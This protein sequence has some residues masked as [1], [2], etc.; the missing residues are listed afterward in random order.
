[1]F[2]KTPAA[3]LAKAVAAAATLAPGDG[4]RFQVESTL[5]T[6]RDDGALEVQATDLVDSYWFT[7]RPPD[8]STSKPGRAFVGSENLARI[9]KRAGKADV[10]IETVKNALVVSWGDTV[11]KLPT[12]NPADA[13]QVVRYRPNDPSISI[14]ATALMSIMAKVNFA[15]SGDFKHR[16][17]AFV[18]VDIKRGRI[19]FAA[20]DGIRFAAVERDVETTDEVLDTAFVQPIK[21]ARIK[22]L[23]GEQDAQDLRVQVKNGYVA[24]STGDAEM[25]VRAG[26]VTWQDFDI[27]RVV[28][29]TKRATIGRSDLLDFLAGAG[30]L[31]TTGEKTCDFTFADGKLSMNA[32][33]PGEGSIQTSTPI[34]W[35][36]ESFMMRFDPVL[37]AQATS[38]CNGDRVELGLSTDQQPVLLRDAVDNQLYL[39]ALGARF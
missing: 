3:R 27:E 28:P 1:V 22:S 20:T 30:L 15:V 17:L 19:R 33:A 31:K 39:Y 35:T 6:V 37:L 11:V 7:V 32:V 10:T 4:K 13:P 25:S 8:P 16:A 24:L 36:H 21:P 34:E 14:P 5:L 9:V 12:E 2:F 26:A 29:V 23:I 18:R 38:Q